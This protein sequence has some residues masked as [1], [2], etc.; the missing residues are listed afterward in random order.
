LGTNPTAAEDA[1]AQ[2]KALLQKLPA[3]AIRAENS[4]NDPAALAE[5]NRTHPLHSTPNTL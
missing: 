1:S 2:L 4:P 3:V 5:L